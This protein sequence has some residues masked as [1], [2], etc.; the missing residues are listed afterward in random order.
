MTQNVSL[1]VDQW[2][3]AVENEPWDVTRAIAKIVIANTTNSFCFISDLLF[4]VR[5]L[6]HRCGMATSSINSNSAPWQICLQFWR[7]LNFIFGWRLFHGMCSWMMKSE[8]VDQ[9]YFLQTLLKL[10]EKVLTVLQR[11][12]TCIAE[13]VWKFQKM[14]YLI[15]FNEAI[16]YWM[17][18]QYLLK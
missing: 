9:R 2:S 15:I 17:G 4:A 10:M 18:H 7:I 6:I 11:T 16:L 8:K 1:A 14:R 5:F 12:Y 3:F 13:S